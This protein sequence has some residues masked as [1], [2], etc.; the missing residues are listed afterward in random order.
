MPTDAD[1]S[2]LLHIANAKV[3]ILLLSGTAD[4]YNDESRFAALKNAATNAPSIDEIWYPDIDHGL[5]GVE[6]QTAD[7][8]NAWITKIGA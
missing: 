2:N 4:S 8:L 7:D 5:A 6:E 1:S 3:P